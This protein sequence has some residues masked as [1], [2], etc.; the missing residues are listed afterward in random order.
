MLRQFPVSCTLSRNPFTPWQGDE[1][2]TLKDTKYIQYNTAGSGQLSIHPTLLR[3]MNG[4]TGIVAHLHSGTNTLFA[5]Q[6]KKPNHPQRRMHW[7]LWQQ[8]VNVD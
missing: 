2:I 7:R 8:Q 4:R 5:V 1:L 6:W 3:E